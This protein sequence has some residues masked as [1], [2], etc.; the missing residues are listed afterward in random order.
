MLQLVIPNYKHKKSYPLKAD[1]FIPAKKLIVELDGKPYHQ[2]LAKE[3]LR[4]QR[5]L[6]MASDLETELYL[7]HLEFDIPS[8][9]VYKNLYGRDRERVKSEYNRWKAQWISTAVNFIV[10][11]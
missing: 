9:L 8:H 2:D 6:S 11:F 7:E 10:N 4:D 1:M 5:I 3:R